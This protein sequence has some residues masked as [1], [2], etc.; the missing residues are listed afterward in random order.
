M[1]IDVTG[2]HPRSK[3]GNVF[4][5]TMMDNFTKFVEVVPMANQ[6][7]T[8]VAKAFVEAVVVRY[9]VPLQILT[10]QG[11]NFEGNIFQEMC[12]LLEIDK[13]RTSSYHP[14][15]NGMIERFHRTL[16]AMIGKLVDENQK[17]WD[18]FLPYVAAAYRASHHDAT[19]FSPNYL[20][21]AKENRAPLDIVYGSPEEDEEERPTYSAYV[22][23][24]KDKFD[25]AYGLARQNLKKAAERRK[26]NYDLRVRATRYE[27]GDWVFYFTS[28]MYVGRSPKWQ[29]NYTG[30]FMVIRKCGP[31]NSLLQKWR[32]AKPFVAHVDKLRICHGRVKGQWGLSTALETTIDTSTGQVAPE[33]YPTRKIEK[34][35]KSRKGVSPETD[36]PMKLSVGVSA[37]GSSEQGTSV[38]DL[39]L[40]TRNRPRRC[41]R[42]PVRFQ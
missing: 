19:G 9:G 42:R 8:T 5:L 25:E 27:V 38:A 36:G 24:L 6:E 41:A 17:N 18:D 21:F 30:T 34:P 11:R 37:E 2:P 14:Q 22:A 33:G 3:R 1:S 28:R 23:D 13:V 31:V 32:K 39:A 40:C 12:R 26:H 4:I 7:A 10:D 35:I 16:H 20:M 15:C 29:K